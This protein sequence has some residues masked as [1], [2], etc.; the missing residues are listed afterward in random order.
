MREAELSVGVTRFR[1]VPASAVSVAVEVAFG[2]PRLVESA[3]WDGTTESFVADIAG[4]RTFAFG[5]EVQSFV[6]A[7]LARHVA[8]TSVV[9]LTKDEVLH[10]GRPFTASEPVRH[11]MLDLIGDL[12]LYGGPPLGRVEAYRPGHG[13][14]HAI[15]VRALDEGVLERFSD[16]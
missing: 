5:D 14:T 15:V 6:D 12:F 7:G 8:P 9:V 11:K 2:D 3:E 16:R 1:F 10:A 13:S 4:A